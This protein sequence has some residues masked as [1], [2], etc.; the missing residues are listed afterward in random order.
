[1]DK[2]FESY[3]SQIVMELECDKDEKNEIAEEIGDHL[4]LLKQEYIEQGFTEEMAK[5]KA[6]GSFGEEKQLRKGYK[7][8]IN[9]YHKI[10]NI[11]NWV[12]FSLYSFV[13]LWKL[14]FERTIVRVVNYN[15]GFNSNYF[16]FSAGR[17]FFNFDMDVWKANANIIPFKNTI[18]YIIHNDRFNLDIVISNTLGNILIFIPLGIFVPILLKRY[19]KLSKLTVLTII[20]SLLF[21]SIQIII[22]IGQ[23][24]IDDIIL[25]CTGSIVGLLFVK[26]MMKFPSFTRKVGIRLY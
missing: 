14:L 13:L 9:P 24:D 26:Y 11:I 10:F 12:L 25:N 19:I 6:I 2:E 5:S 16:F 22:Q 23:F 3:I 17:G 1:M 18:N 15:N 21:E 20:I 8:S 7:E 4:N